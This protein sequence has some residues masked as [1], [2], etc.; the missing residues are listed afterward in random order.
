MLC[1]APGREDS[2]VVDTVFNNR[3]LELHVNPSEAWNLLTVRS[4]AIERQSSGHGALRT[5]DIAAMLAGLHPEP[6]MMGMAAEC[7]DYKALRQIELVLWT[8]A[9]KIAE[10]ER[11]EPPRGEFTV[12]R[13]A[14]LA[15]YEAI[16]D[17]RCYACNGEGHMEFSLQTHPGLIM[18]PSYRELNVASGTIRCPACQGSGQIRLSGRKK[19]DLAGINKDSWTRQWA[20]R[21]EPV[22]RIAND[23][24]EQA[25]SY[26]AARMREAGKVDN[27]PVSELPQAKR[28]GHEKVFE[29]NASCEKVKSE[30]SSRSRITTPSAKA[31]PKVL[32]FEALQRP[33]LTVQ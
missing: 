12:R 30:I 17:R 28:F 18:A 27:V 19:A 25:R 20:R 3:T 9:N 16:D 32:A 5:A 15:L 10:R 6:Y 33:V 11:W 2:A 4:S 29:I 14:A 8:R 7:G 24:R 26:L 23:W 1:A 13:M 22:F 21:Y 31:A